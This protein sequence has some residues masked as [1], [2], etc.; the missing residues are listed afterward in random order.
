MHIVCI[1]VEADKGRTAH[2]N[3]WNGDNGKVSTTWNPC[4]IS[5]Y[6]L[7]S[8]HY[9]EPSS[10]QQPPLMYMMGLK[11]LTSR[12]GIHIKLTQSVNAQIILRTGEGFES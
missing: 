8:S 1:S 10:P 7:H 6:S 4:L 5:F 3:G 9:Y 12:I 11:G 2:S